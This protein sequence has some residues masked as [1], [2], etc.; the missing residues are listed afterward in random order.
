MKPS[1]VTMRTLVS[2]S[3]A[4]PLMIFFVCPVNNQAFLGPLSP[5]SISSVVPGT[6]CS[7]WAD[8]S[9]AIYNA[10]DISTSFVGKYSNSN[11][12]T[13]YFRWI[14]STHVYNKCAI[15][16]EFN[17]VLSYNSRP[18]IA[19]FFAFSFAFLATSCCFKNPDMNSNS[20]DFMVST[21]LSKRQLASGLAVM[22]GLLA[23]AK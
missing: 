14:D 2:M 7:R 11:S 6:Q 5:H 16:L 10:G 19:R 18:F 8:R 20:V 23:A 4:L 3:L 9:L 17:Q 22:T 15:G 13:F 21:T 12:R 1:L